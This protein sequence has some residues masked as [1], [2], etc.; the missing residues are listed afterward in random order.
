MS[1][2]LLLC[3]N[4]AY[5][6][7]LAFTC[8][9]YKRVIPICGCGCAV[10]CCWV[11]GL[12]RSTSR[13]PTLVTEENRSKEKGARIGFIGWLISRLVCKKCGDVLH[14]WVR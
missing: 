9:I 8:S 4:P 10:G 11:A 13:D 2:H 5:G 14:G 6:F 3:S 1:T 12:T 7:P